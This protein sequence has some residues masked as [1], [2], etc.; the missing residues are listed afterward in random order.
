MIL[1]TGSVAGLVAGAARVYGSTKGA[2]HQLTKA[3]AVEGAPF[4]IR[5]QRHLPGRACPTPASWPPAG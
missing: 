1:N 2:V 5:V 4:G 3:V